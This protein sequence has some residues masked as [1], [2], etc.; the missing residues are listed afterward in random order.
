VVLTTD[1][2]LLPLAISLIKLA[3]TSRMALLVCAICPECLTLWLSWFPAS[4]ARCL[5]CRQCLLLLAQ[6][7]LQLFQALEQDFHGDTGVIVGFGL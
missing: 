3:L 7:L 5:S 4:V 1:P 6:L 2:V